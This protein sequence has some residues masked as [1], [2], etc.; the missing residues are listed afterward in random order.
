MNAVEIVKKALASSGEVVRYITERNSTTVEVGLGRYG[1][2][3]YI[4]NVE[5]GKVINIVSD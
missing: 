1:V 5:T 3:Y 4:V 2:C